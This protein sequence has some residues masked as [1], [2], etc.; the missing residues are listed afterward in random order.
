VS[1]TDLEERLAVR[2]RDNDIAQWRKQI[3]DTEREIKR[4]E[5]RKQEIEEEI[6]RLEAG[7]P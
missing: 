6:A 2:L 7:R 3:A 5:R 1:D 4:L